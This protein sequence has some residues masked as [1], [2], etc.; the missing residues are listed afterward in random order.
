MNAHSA[1]RE[2]RQEETCLVGFSFEFQA[3][4]ESN[5]FVAAQSPSG[6]GDSDNGGSDEEDIPEFVVPVVVLS[7]VAFL[8]LIAIGIMIVRERSGT[9]LFKPLAESCEEGTRVPPA[10]AGNQL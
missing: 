1:R 8:A 3:G 10:N 5:F 4:Y 7:S 2:T 6:D 9:P